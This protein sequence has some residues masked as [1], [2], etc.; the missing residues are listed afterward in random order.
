M[1]YELGMTATPCLAHAAEEAPH[2]PGV[3]FF[4]GADAELLYVGKAGSLR[5]RLRQHARAKR[6]SGGRRLDV[7]YERLTEVRCEELPDEDGAA[8][9]E[10][11]LIVALRPAFN[12]SHAGEGRWNYVLVHPLGVD[13]HTLRFTLSQQADIT[14]GRVY[15]CFPHL[16]RGVSSRPA[17]ACSDGY[18]A[19]LR[20]L[21]ARSS[22]PRSH[23]P[24]RITRS[25]P[26]TFEAQVDPS[27]RSSLHAFFSGTSN[28][29]LAE[30]VAAV[31]PRGGYVPRIPGRDRKAAGS[32]FVHGP[33]ALRRL[34]LRHQRPPGPM[35]R[36]VIED[37]LAAEVREA[38]GEFRLPTPP[39]ARD[40]ILGRRARRWARP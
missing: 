16:G 15:G 8:A 23:I 25:A 27:A 26:D 20:L 6:G 21:W 7:L 32:F 34:R 3:Y 28:R 40:E 36:A 29:L 9:R 22:S 37:L 38:I 19:L 10:A 4:L 24:S 1:H 13:N 17:I 14:A 12:A 18:T 39:D 33:R 35:P 2:A 31:E 30:L 11:D 5:N